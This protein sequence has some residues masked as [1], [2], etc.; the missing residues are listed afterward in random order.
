[1]FL[2]LHRKL[3]DV[4]D[5]EILDSATRGLRIMAHHESPGIGG[6][7]LTDTAALAD[8]LVPYV[9]RDP[10]D[11]KLRLRYMREERILP[12]ARTGRKA[13]D[14]LP[15]I[16]AVHGA[17]ALVALMIGGPQIHAAAAVRE[18]WW[19]PLYR[20][21]LGPGYSAGKSLALDDDGVRPCFGEA[22]IDAI[23]FMVAN[24]Q[25]EPGPDT[26]I[27]L[28]PG[29]HSYVSYQDV[30]GRNPAHTDVFLGGSTGRMPH[31]LS[32]VTHTIVPGGLVQRLARFI[33][34]CRES[35]A[36]QGV[37]IDTAEAYEALRFP[38]EL[39]AMPLFPERSRRTPES[40]KDSEPLNTTA[41]PENTKAAEGTTPPATF[42]ETP[43]MKPGAAHNG[44]YSLSL[45]KRATADSRSVKTRPR[46]ESRDG[47]F[48]RQNPAGHAFA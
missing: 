16:E 19:A 44:A 46:G 11:T 13:R 7:F 27:G 42:D 30:P 5:A 33:T 20:R 37:T 21:E 10:A 32:I 2:L 3:N 29:N 22:V 45:T 36:Q 47:Q 12:N 43:A 38:P 24:P 34:I 17:A 1:M 41:E 4:K 40:A 35:A 18:R 39:P 26:H 14:V 48:A 15:Q 6:A 28:R 8:L 31:P 9:G 25:F 23:E